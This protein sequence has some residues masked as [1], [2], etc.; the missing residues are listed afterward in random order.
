MSIGAMI[1]LFFGFIMW[2]M[3][4]RRD[5]ELDPHGNPRLIYLAPRIGMPLLTLAA[6][7]A[8]TAIALQARHSP[9]RDDF[10]ATCLLFGVIVAGSG[11][12][13]LYFMGARVTLTDSAIVTR[14]MLFRTRSYPLESI[15]AWRRLEKPQVVIVEFAGGKKLKFYAMYSG[16]KFFLAEL[17]RRVPRRSG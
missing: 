2:A 16:L 1:G 11:L 9:A 7:A 8:G 3:F 5:R 6:A 14:D 13:S 12:A 4:I 10:A 17:E 15:V